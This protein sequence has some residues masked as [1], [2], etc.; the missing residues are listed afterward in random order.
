MYGTRDAAKNWERE[1]QQTMA[2]LGFQAGKAMTPALWHKE[3]D[4]LAVVHG[5]DVTVLA[6]QGEG[7]WMKGQLATRYNVRP[8]ATPGPDSSDDKSARI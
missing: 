7:G 5:D 4:I 1:Y 3:R 6:N 8:N 2:G